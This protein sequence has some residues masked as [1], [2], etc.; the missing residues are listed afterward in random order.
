VPS[1]LVLP[2]PQRSASTRDDFIVTPANAEAIAFIDAWPDWPVAAAAIYGPS[3]S[4][5]SH[6]AAIWSAAAKA[7][8]ISAAELAGKLE[9]ASAAPTPFI[10]EDVDLAPP[11]M[12]RDLALFSLFG[13]ASREAPILL[14]GREPPKEWA[15]VVPDLA[16]RFSALLAFPLW[17]PD[18]ALLAGLARKL[19]SDRQLEVP[20]AV[21]ARM[22]NALERSPAAFRDFVADADAKALAEAKAINLAL[23]RD[24]L[25]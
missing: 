10:V 3:G 13:R 18:D 22:L 5:K 8:S 17:A 7:E 16:S 6:A 24:M 2:L 23:I 14:T 21:I 25:S 19:F 20:D 11:T 12:E 1:Q 4:G 9:T 15:A